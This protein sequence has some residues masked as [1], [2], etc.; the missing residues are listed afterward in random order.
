MPSLHHQLHSL[1]LFL[2][3]LPCVSVWAYPTVLEVAR[4]REVAFARRPFLGA[5]GAVLPFRAMYI[6]QL[7]ER[8]ARTGEYGPLH[9]WASQHRVLFLAWSSICLP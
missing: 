1:N 7:R 6:A 9:I 8:H 4:R 5:L 3:S 2:R